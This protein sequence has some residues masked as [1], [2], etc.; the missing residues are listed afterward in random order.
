MVGTV[1]NG[2]MHRDLRLDV[3]IALTDTE[4]TREHLRAPSFR[5]VAL[6]RARHFATVDGESHDD[7]KAKSDAVPSGDVNALLTEDVTKNPVFLY[8]KGVPT[9]P[10]CG[11]S[12]MACQILD[13]Y[14][15]KFGSRN[16]LEDQDVREGIKKFSNWPTIP[17]IY[18]GGEF[19]GGSDILL[20]LHN[21][22]DLDK[23]LAPIVQAQKAQK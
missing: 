3:A 13:A 6:S 11:F 4:E 1:H 12:N 20:N 14:G 9:A 7:F 2:S 10:Q 23:M 21:S 16:V 15:V 5:A 22:G 17:Q 19:V 8:M 18:I